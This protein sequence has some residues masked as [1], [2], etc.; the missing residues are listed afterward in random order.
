MQAGLLLH[1]GQHPV[2]EVPDDAPAGGIKYWWERYVGKFF[3][4]VAFAAI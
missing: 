2:K 1:P 4:V 3:Y